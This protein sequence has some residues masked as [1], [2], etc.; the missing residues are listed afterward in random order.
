M[1]KRDLA[2]IAAR[3]FN[4]PLLIDPRKAI[5]LSSVLAEH[6]SGMATLSD[7]REAQAR[8]EETRAGRA[9]MLDRF[10]GE[11]RGPKVTN[12]YGDT[13]T[14][15]RYLYRDGVALVTVE[16][17][18]VNRGAWIGAD[19][20]LTSY[21]G[22]MSQ[23]AS[24]AADRD[25]RS[26]ILDLESPGGEAVGA[27]EMADFVRAITDEKPV[28][29]LVNGMAASAAYAMASGA[30]RIVTTPSGVSGSI[31]VVML[32]LDQSKRLEKAGVT[33]T[34]IFAGG[35]KVDGNP[36]E[37][38]PEDVRDEF[39]AEVDK[40]YSMFVATVAR[41]RRAMTED[42]IRATEARTFIGADA[43]GVGLA[44]EV[45][46]F[47]E[48]VRSLQPRGGSSRIMSQGATM[49]QKEGAAGADAPVY[50]QAQFDAALAGARADAKKEGE[51]SA[52]KELCA[53]LAELFP[54]NQR[55]ATFVEAINDGATVALAAKF[56]GKIEEP[57]AGAKTHRL[58]ALAPNPQIDADQPAS[59]AAGIANKWRA[60]I[61]KANARIRN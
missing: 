24:A 12:A 11:R 56:A 15:T 4:T 52:R 23:L 59:Q 29:A 31:G 27:F 38:L 21:E 26:I 7:T 20:G 10:D 30:K 40:L 39:Q 48:I 37:P 49:S 19:S 43:V 50:T 1:M 2:H 25:V 54:G 47:T 42:A 35:H 36:F 61:D 13:Y 3:A 17:S 57:K 41:G 28:I 53:S 44:D 14:Q 32:H 55:A 33:P 45:G 9:E 5:V 51:E 18:L 22:V 6:I 34:L 60:A 16:G 58:D 8:A 46:I